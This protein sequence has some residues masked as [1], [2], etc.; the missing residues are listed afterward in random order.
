MSCI[1]CGDTG[2]LAPFPNWEWLRNE[3]Y[4]TFLQWLTDREC[5]GC[6]GA[7]NFCIPKP[8]PPPPAPPKT[9]PPTDDGL[10]VIRDGLLIRLSHIHQFEFN[11]PYHKKGYIE[12]RFA[13]EVAPDKMQQAKESLESVMCISGG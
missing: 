6:K 13:G 11:V 12:I 7:G 4:G 8:P 9:K 1:I 3:V 5:Y 2:N 10:Y